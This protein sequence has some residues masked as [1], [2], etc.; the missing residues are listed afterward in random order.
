VRDGAELVV[1]LPACALPT[2]ARVAERVRRAVEADL[3]RSRPDIARIT[4][5]LGVVERG[6]QEP[7]PDVLAR[8]R[9]AVEAAAARGGNRVEIG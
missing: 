6:P 7:K 8:A 3:I 1:L 9:A 5:S 2:A 4:V